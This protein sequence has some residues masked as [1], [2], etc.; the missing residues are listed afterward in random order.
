[1]ALSSV[2]PVVH[3]VDEISIAVSEF[4]LEKRTRRHEAPRLHWLRRTLRPVQTRE[5]RPRPAGTLIQGRTRFPIRD[6]IRLFNTADTNCYLKAASA[7]WGLLHSDATT[8]YHGNRCRKCYHYGGASF[9]LILRKSIHIGENINENE[10]FLQ[11]LTLTND[12][13]LSYNYPESIRF[14][15]KYIIKYKNIRDTY[16]FI[17]TQSQI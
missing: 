9:A 11:F 5:R 10:Y 8:F 14:F 13:S 7:P 2:I 15:L 12:L 4:A 17:L 1:M 3:A 6:E 16:F